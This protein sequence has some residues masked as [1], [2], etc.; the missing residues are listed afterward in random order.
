MMSQEQNDLMTRTG[1]KDAC[2]KLMRMYWQP[3]ALVD[4][5][6]G[7]RPVRPVKLLGEDLVLFRD[8][9]GHY[10]LIERHCAHRGAD[11][12]FGRLENGGL[13]CAFQGSTLC[14][15]IRQ[16]AYPVVEKSGILWA[17]LGEG[18]PP[19]FPEIDCFVAPETHTFAFKGHINCNWLQAL[20]VG[21]DPSHASFLHRFF[22]DED[23]SGAYGRQFRG[24]SAGSEMPMTKILREYDRPIINVEQTEYGFRL[25]ALREI[26]EER[27][28][29][30][31]TN[32]LF[33]NGFVIPMSTEMTISQWHV[34]ID[35]ENC[36][37]YAIFTS[38]TSAVDKNKMRDQR[39]ELYELPDYR[40]RKNRSNDYGFDPHEQATQTFTGMGSDINVHDQWAVESMGAIQDRTREH[41]GQADKAIVQYRRLLRQEAEKAASGTR[42]FM[43][44][45]AA[46]ARS[47][48]GPATMD[49]IGPTRG[50]ETF[51]MEVDVKRRRSA[52]WAAPVPQ[53]IADQIPHLRAVQ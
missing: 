16:R 48:Q 39:L 49:G 47:I 37:W 13:R 4:E 42:P 51:W 34:P 38:Y 3:A 44:L 40:S 18:E 22:E 53:E 14:Q 27:T 10:G 17:Y 6:E 1:P 52:P 20:E 23:T 43:F 26:D 41:L 7:P 46:H 31:V 36:Y 24:A 12:A 29:V 19:A 21:I 32:Q 28:H 8:E 50:W 2:G 33:P 5:L 11:L 45:D 35:D 9:Q 15:G 25:I 30:R